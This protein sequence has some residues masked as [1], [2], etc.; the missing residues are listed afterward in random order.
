[1]I[2]R[3]LV[4]EDS[5]EL[6]AFTA[7]VLALGGYDVVTA[8]SGAEAERVLRTSRVDVVVTDLRMPYMSG[9]EVLKLAKDVDAETVVI[10]ITGFPTVDTAVKAMKAGAADYLMKPFSSEQLLKIVG[11]AV[12]ARASREAYTQ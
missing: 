8:G 4:V 7:E 12:A 3:V 5:A 1:M 9:I 2:E 11:D 6:L 10:V